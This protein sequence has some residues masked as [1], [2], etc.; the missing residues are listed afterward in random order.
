MFFYDFDRLIQPLDSA[1]FFNEYWE[2]R[3]LTIARK[4]PDY[5]S[6]LFSMQDVD[7]VICFNEPKYPAIQLFSN[8]K[9]LPWNSANER[10]GMNSIRELYNEYYKGSTIILRGLQHR[11]KPI[12]D[13]YRS[14]ESFFN[15]R[16]H[17]N[18]YLT[19]KDSQGFSAHFDT[20]EVFILQIEGSKIWRIYDTFQTLPLPISQ[21]P[22]PQDKLREPLY[23]ILLN[24]GDL[25]YIPSGYVHE[26]LTS[27]CSSLHL[28]VGI[29][30][31]RWGDLLSTALTSVSERNLSF[32]KSLP[33]GFL[34]C[35][36]TIGS[37]KYQF[38]ELLELFLSSAKVED[39]VER[40]SERVIDEM[41]PLPD[42]HFTQIDNV[43]SIGLDTVVEKRKGMTCRIVR[44]QD[45][46]SIQFPGNRVKGPKH[47]TLR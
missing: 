4:E 10:A 21:Q 28:T 43:N 35:S 15:H 1:T 27:E 40:L 32:R 37:L 25:L 31:Y 45:S 14:L 17:V 23:E 7:T 44:E 20:H 36:E 47:S 22:I 6:S 34:K 30:V 26:A 29:N 19:P 16:V 46:V 39:A 24:A 42:G 12:S 2:Q 8:G 11:W 9:S 13:L 38:E 41:P 18:M 3:P 33:V 5:Y